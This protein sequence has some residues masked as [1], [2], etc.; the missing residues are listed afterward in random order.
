MKKAYNFFKVKL[1]YRTYW[2]QWLAFLA[3]CFLVL[4]CSGDDSS[5]SS[6]SQNFLEKYDGVIW[7]NID[8][9]INDSNGLWDIFTPDGWEQTSYG[10]VDSG[11][12][13]TFYTP[14]NIVG[15]YGDW[16]KAE[17]IDN[18]IDE[19]IIEVTETDS[20]TYL[21]YI[22]AINNGNSLH[23]TS[24]LSNEED[25]YTRDTSSNICN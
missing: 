13:E 16:I 25:Y 15:N 8:E 24:S 9:D 11:I 22:T 1:C 12:C 3:I 19:L 21:I 17:V 18:S 23:F 20:E 6:S 7:K 10:Y 4:A 14:W 2:K 5:S